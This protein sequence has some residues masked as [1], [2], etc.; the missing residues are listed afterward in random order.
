MME[1]RNFRLRSF[2]CCIA[3][4]LVCGCDGTPTGGG[5]E[6]YYKQ[7]PERPHLVELDGVWLYVV[8]DESGLDIINV[9]NPG[10]PTIFERVPGTAGEAV[11][12]FRNRHRLYIAYE[13]SEAGCTALAG[14]DGTW[15]HHAWTEFS[16][17]ASVLDAPLLASRF[18]V[19]GSYHGSVKQGD[20]LYVLTRVGTGG[21]LLSIDVSDP[22]SPVL[23]DVEHDERG[24]PGSSLHHDRQALHVV[25]DTG[26]MALVRYID[27]SDDD[28]V[29][30]PRDEVM[31]ETSYSS[32]VFLDHH[33]DHL[34]VVVERGS[35]CSIQVLDVTDPDEIVTVPVPFNF[36]SPERLWD[37]RFE[38]DVIFVTTYTQHPGTYVDNLRIISREDPTYLHHLSVIQ[39]PS[40]SQGFTIVGDQLIAI[41]RGEQAT[42]VAVTV[43]K[44]VNL[45]GP[46]WVDT[47]TFGDADGPTGWYLDVRGVGVMQRGELADPPVV[48]VPYTRFLWDGYECIPERH[49]QLLDVRWTALQV[50]GDWIPPERHGR[51]EEVV[52]V[53]NK[54]YAISDVSVAVIGLMDRDAPQEHMSLSLGGEPADGCRDVQPF[55]AD[56]QGEVVSFFDVGC[57]V[58]GPGGTSPPVV[59]ALLLAAVALLL[60]RRSR[61]GRSGSCRS[62]SPRAAPGPPG[63]SAPPR[64]WPGPRDRTWRC[65]G[66]P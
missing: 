2:G 9:G 66:W 50:R 38:G 1:R 21:L 46:R 60:S 27:I 44:V 33:V 24:S 41:G 34:F 19:P 35:G 6:I 5:D 13:S 26:S 36:A 29:I 22:F 16:I 64:P 39:I 58:A 49:L 54:V 20:F 8:D 42:S 23:A 3:C 62:A 61:C 11:D 37:V 65:P 47:E 18:C 45:E 63:V 52:Q 51:T 28:G 4:L 40:W 7:V 30:V 57:S 59:L 12:M 15:D 14:L 43:Y 55:L 17:V 10:S 31:I 56:E 32:P 48:V 53:G 25:V